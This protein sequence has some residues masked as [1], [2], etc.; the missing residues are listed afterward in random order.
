MYIFWQLLH[1]LRGFISSQSRALW[2]R[3]KSIGCYEIW[4]SYISENDDVDIVDFH[5]IYIRRWVPALWRNILLLSW[6]L[7]IETEWF[8]DFEH[9]QQFSTWKCFPA[10]AKWGFVS[11]IVFPL[12]LKLTLHLRCW[13]KY[14]TDFLGVWFLKNNFKLGVN[15]LDHN[16]M[17]CIYFYRLNKNWEM[18][19]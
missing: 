1:W 12:I 5:V 16:L 8:S 14:I 15:A 10:D 18:K 4:G 13:Y 17:E 6:S 7:K 11:W 9:M 2:C 3:G 19:I